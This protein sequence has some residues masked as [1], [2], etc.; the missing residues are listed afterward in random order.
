MSKTK[1][2][3]MELPTMGEVLA[4]EDIINTNAQDNRWIVIAPDGRMWGGLS[5]DDITKL[6]AKVKEGPPLTPA[7]VE[8]RNMPTMG[9]G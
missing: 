4:L 3:P 8:L 1:E 6:V 2:I 5:I 9:N 7:Q